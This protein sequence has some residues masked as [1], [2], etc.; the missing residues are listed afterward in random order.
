MT[1][2]IS[3]LESALKSFDALLKRTLDTEYM[4][5]LDDVARYGLRAGV[6]QNF[7]FTYELCWK[8]MRRWIEDNIG[9]SAV[10]G[11]PRIE[12]FRCAAENLLIED[13]MRWADY[14]KA[15]NLTSHTYNPQ[16]A[17]IVFS[18]MSNFLEDAKKFLSSLNKRNV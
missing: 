10:D 5:R 8:F 11:V 4:S 6:I 2:D 1:L 17:D 13:M 16:T 14:H 9:T 7:E 12:L 18:K 15:R 3:G